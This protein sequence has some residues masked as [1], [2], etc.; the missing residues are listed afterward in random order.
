[1]VPAHWSREQADAVFMFLSGVAEQ[2]WIAHESELACVA[3][4]ETTGGKVR[5]VR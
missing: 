3:M 2:V 5:Q 4:E 1:M